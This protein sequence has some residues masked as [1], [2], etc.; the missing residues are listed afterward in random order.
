MSDIYDVLTSTPEKQ[1]R[2]PAF[3]Q[4]DWIQKKKDEKAELYASIDNEATAVV[5]DSGKLLCYLNLQSR[6]DLYS[7][8]NCLLIAK[9]AP[10]ARQ[11]KDYDGWKQAGGNVRQGEKGISILEPGE[12]Y[13]RKDG[14]TGISYNVKKVFDI[15]QVDGMEELRGPVQRDTRSLLRALV[16]QAPVPIRIMDDFTPSEHLAFYS[17]VGREVVVRKG[18]DNET[19]LYAVLAQE[20]AHATLDDGKTYER[21]KADFPAEMASYMLCKRY[22]IEEACQ[23][24]DF[25]QLPESFTKA[26]AG[27]VRGTLSAARKALC[28]LHDRMNRSLAPQAKA[29]SDQEN[30]R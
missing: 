30:Q 13:Q 14:T 27:A 17:P 4:D 11:L 18:I 23:K 8:A 2:K 28:D 7:A 1:E 10:D 16:N 19:V 12:R 26:D 6:L 21:A 25:T 29:K 5:G 3:N 15:T 20:M 24:F 22:G 9:V